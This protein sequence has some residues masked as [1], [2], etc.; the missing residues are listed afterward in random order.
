MALATQKT[1]THPEL[2]NLNKWATLVFKGNNRYT[3]NLPSTLPTRIIRIET[4]NGTLRKIT[5]FRQIRN[6]QLGL[7]HGFCFR[8]IVLRTLMTRIYVVAFSHKKKLMQLQL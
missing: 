8:Q 1:Q 3:D 6:Q 7:V 4:Q 2:K 5:G